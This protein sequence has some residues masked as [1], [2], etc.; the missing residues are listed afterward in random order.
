MNVFRSEG[1]E[2]L[3]A[4]A[5]TD[6]LCLT[7][8][9]YAVRRSVYIHGEDTDP[10]EIL[11]HHAGRQGP[12]HPIVLKTRNFEWDIRCAVTC[13]E[14]CEFHV[15][16]SMLWVPCCEFHVVSSMLWVPCCE[17]HVV[18]SM[19]WVPCC[20]FHV[21]SSMLWVPCCEFHVV[22]CVFL[23][24]GTTSHVLGMGKLFKIPG[25]WWYDLALIAYES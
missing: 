12:A 18:S 21:V 1:I 22:P 19:L 5:D 24:C 8:I 25:C 4:E 14:H 17:F 6:Y 2:C 16:S 13:P 7:A 10:L 3:P 11:I 20:V 15:V 23:G 9:Q